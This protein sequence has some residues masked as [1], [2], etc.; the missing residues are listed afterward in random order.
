MKNIPVKRIKLSDLKDRQCRFP[1]GDPRD[2]DFA[3]CGCGAMPG[4][5]YCSEHAKVAYQAAT[6]KKLL[7]SDDVDTAKKNDTA[8]EALDNLRRQAN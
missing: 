6:R 7:I 5:P 2:E 3:F 4:I 1:L 8:E